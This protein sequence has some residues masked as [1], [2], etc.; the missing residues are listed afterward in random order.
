MTHA[1]TD[2]DADCDR[3]LCE[4]NPC[5]EASKPPIDIAALN[6]KIES[7]RA[8]RARQFQISAQTT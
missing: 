3:S 8:L 1:D 7:D 4:A 6:A 2:H 5:W